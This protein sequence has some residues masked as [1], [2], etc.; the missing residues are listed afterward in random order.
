[1]QAINKLSTT[2]GVL[3]LLCVG[4]EGSQ[5]SI[6]VD[7]FYQGNWWRCSAKSWLYDSR[8]GKGFVLNDFECPSQG[9]EF[10]DN[11]AELV[12]ELNKL[13]VNSATV[14]V[15]IAQQTF[16]AIRNY[17]S[18]SNNGIKNR[19]VLELALLDKASTDGIS[20]QVYYP[21][22]NLEALGKYSYSLQINQG[23]PIKITSGV[24]ELTGNGGA[25]LYKATLDLSQLQVKIVK[26]DSVKLIY[27]ANSNGLQEALIVDTSNAPPAVTGV[28]PSTPI[29]PTPDVNLSCLA[30]NAAVSW[31]DARY[32]VMY[33]S[34][35][36]LVIINEQKDGST[37]LPGC[38]GKV[39]APPNSCRLGGS[40]AAE[41]YAIRFTFNG[42][43][44]PNNNAPDPIVWDTRDAMTEATELNRLFL[45]AISA[46]P[47]DFS[48]S[49]GKSCTYGIA[50]T[51]GKIYVADT[52]AQ[53][54]LS[55]AYKNQTCYL[56]ANHTYYINIRPKNTSCVDDKGVSSPVPCRVSVTNN[57]PKAQPSTLPPLNSGS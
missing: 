20:L 12:K 35:N 29:T 40:I 13:P 24:T 57:I 47:D 41:R 38:V 10:L 46:K 18:I 27:T 48:N 45:L 26:G 23:M 39:N 15:S 3:G 7:A 21:I 43:N 9:N 34:D 36:Q 53:D 44:P 16:T 25:G 31:Q 17:T 54:V 56:E 1:M 32:D 6:N 50:Y 11:N 55:S 30:N 37:W 42:P 33:C 49:L 19:L 52:R 8:Q 4:I 51:S 5:A 22:N 14:N 28:T 2:A